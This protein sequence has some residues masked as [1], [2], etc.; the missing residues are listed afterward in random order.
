MKISYQLKKKSGTSSLRFLRDELNLYD[1]F[2]ILNM[3]LYDYPSN[4]DSSFRKY[5]NTFD[6]TLWMKIL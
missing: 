6:N 4:M 1:V 3:I 5:Q 2:R